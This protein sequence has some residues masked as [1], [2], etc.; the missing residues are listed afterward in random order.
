MTTWGSAATSSCC[1]RGPEI[2]EEFLEKLGP[3]SERELALAEDLALTD[4]EFWSLPQTL[5]PT[6]P[7]RPFK[8]TSRVCSRPSFTRPTGEAGCG[9]D[10]RRRRKRSPSRSS[11]SAG[12]NSRGGEAVAQGR[13][14]AEGCPT[15]VILRDRLLTSRCDEPIAKTCGV[16]GM[17]M[18]AAPRSV[19]QRQRLQSRSTKLVC[20]PWREIARARDSTRLLINSHRRV[21]AGEP[22][23][24]T[25]V[26]ATAISWP[27]SRGA[28]V[29][30]ELVGIKQREAGGWQLG[31]YR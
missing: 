30:T 6:T 2:G 12:P 17:R 3:T 19:R 4:A 27:S 26:S 23:R 24:P 10:L 8:S 16:P 25:P 9:A 22:R 14:R 18:R 29:V 11:R 31:A 20:A 13:K 5:S 28:A 15:R 21:P 1:R 7:R